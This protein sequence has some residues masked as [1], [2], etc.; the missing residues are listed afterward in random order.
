MG[1]N[2]ASRN[3]VQIKIL[4]FTV[5]CCLHW[6]HEFAGAVVLRKTGEPFSD[7]YHI[8]QR[9][10]F[11]EVQKLNRMLSLIVSLPAENAKA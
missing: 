10:V 9:A 7:G 1:K 11:A 6:P 5:H 3:Q 4:N 8:N 2:N